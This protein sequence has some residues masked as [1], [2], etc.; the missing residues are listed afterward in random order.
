MALLTVLTGGKG[1][2][3]T[4]LAA[5]RASATEGEAARKLLEAQGFIIKGGSA[6]NG[7]YETR[8]PFHEGPGAIEP[9]KSSSQPLPRS[10]SRFPRSA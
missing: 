4:N 3:N 10:N 1:K 9:R 5:H 7:Q 6:K 2:A 8:C